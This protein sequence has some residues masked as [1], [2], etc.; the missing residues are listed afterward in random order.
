MYG[1]ELKKLCEVVSLYSKLMEENMKQLKLVI[2][3]RDKCLKRVFEAL[4]EKLYKK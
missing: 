1:E 3:H 4:E 2:E